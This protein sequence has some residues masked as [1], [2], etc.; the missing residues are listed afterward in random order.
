MSRIMVSILAI[1]MSLGS[2]Q[3][4]PMALQRPTDG[5]AVRIDKTAYYNHYY[6][7]HHY[8]HYGYYHHHHYR[9]YAYYRHHR[10]YRHGDAAAAAMFGAVAAGVLSNPCIYGGCGYDYGPYYGGYGG[11]MAVMAVMA[12][13]VSMADFMAAAFTEAGPVSAAVPRRRWLSWRRL[14]GGGG[15]GHH[16]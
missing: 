1:T 4:T 7:R 10:Y 12:A 8:R 16:R 9:H 2:A 15:G 11:G 14:P 6:H 13:D 5:S 3:A